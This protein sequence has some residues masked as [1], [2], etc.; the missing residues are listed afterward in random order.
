MKKIFALLSI[1]C[2]ASVQAIEI[3]HLLGKEVFEQTPIKVVTLDWALTETV[4]SLGVIPQGVAN[5]K[6]YQNWVSKPELSNSVTDVGSR[7]EPNLELLSELKPDVIL[8]SEDMAPAHRQLQKI[9]PTLVFSIYSDRKAPLSAAKQVTSQLGLLLDKQEQATRVIEQTDQLLAENGNK[10]KQSQL[11]SQDLLFVRFIND[12][13]VRVH[14]KGSLAQSTIQGMG[15]TN[16]WQEKTNMWGFTTA[17]IEKLA[18]HQDSNVMIFGPLKADQRAQ[19][20]QSP[21]W[22]AMKFTRT[23]SVYELPPIW[24]FGGLIAAQRF[25]NSITK[26]LLNN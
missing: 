8:I 7:R 20:Q 22:Q 3:K 13:T 21:L 5:V 6:G 25:S 14:S 18:E 4:L 1:F 15:L 23:D 24:T 2:V 16:S 17:G 26:Q 12:K 9:A 11:V 19:L 10:I